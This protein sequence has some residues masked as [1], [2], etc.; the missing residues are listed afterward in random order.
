M[1]LKW[2]AK[3]IVQK[4]ISFFPYREKLNYLFQKYVTRGIDLDDTH[5]AYKIQAAS[6][7]LKYMQKYAHNGILCSQAVLELGTGWYPVVPVA[8]FLS[9]TMSVTSI[10]IRPWMTKK[11]ILIC[12]DKFIEWKERGKLDEYLPAMNQLRWNDIVSLSERR[13]SITKQDLLDKLNLRTMVC[14]ANRTGLPDQSFDFICSNNTFEHIYPEM[15]GAILTEFKRLMKPDGMMSHHIDMSDHFAHFDSSISIYNFL[16]FSRKKW[17]LID[18]RIQPQNRLR[19]SDYIA[20]YSRLKIPVTE[21][22]IWEGNVAELTKLNI[23]PEFAYY[24]AR[25]LAISHAYI[26]SRYLN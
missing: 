6:D 25:D 16:K 23:A 1:A 5:F 17:A 12:L 3:A 26:V 19:Y 21:T 10:D 8:M 9:G 13:D 4:T 14:S 24:S 20:M 22:K 7:H 15:L 11:S 2:V 18:N